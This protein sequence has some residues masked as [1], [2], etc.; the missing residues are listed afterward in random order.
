MSNPKGQ[1]MATPKLTP[2]REQAIIKMIQDDPVDSV[3]YDFTPEEERECTFGVIP[4]RGRFRVWAL[5]DVDSSLAARGPFDTYELAVEQAHA[6]AKETAEAARDNLQ[7]QKEE[8][9]DSRPESQIKVTAPFTYRDNTDFPNGM[10]FDTE[11]EVFA[12]LDRGH[13]FDEDQPASN[14]FQ[15]SLVD[16]NGLEFW[17]KKGPRGEMR[18]VGCMEFDLP[19]DR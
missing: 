5:E 1:N 14:M 18:I 17:M 4:E 13:H 6:W 7:S 19:T 11:E 3:L 16:D 12:F 8:E 9:W 10:E 2:A 15:C